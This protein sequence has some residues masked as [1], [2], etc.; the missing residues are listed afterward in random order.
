VARLAHGFAD[1][2]VGAM[3]LA[4]P[5]DKPLV[6]VPAM[7]HQMLNAPV[8]QENLS[9][10]GR[11]GFM[12]TPTQNGS[13][14]CGEEGEGRMLE[15]EQILAWIFNSREPRGRVL[16]TGG[17]TREPIDGI[18]FLS[19]VSTGQTAA[20]L[21]EEL[22][23]RGWQVTHL[24]GEGAA[25][26]ARAT[27]RIV[28]SS[29]TDLDEKLRRELGAHDYRAVIH[30]AAVSDYSVVDARPDVKLSS[31][32]NLH[33]ELKRNFKILP[34]LREY[35]RDKKLVVIGFKLTLG[36][37]PDATRAAA[38]AILDASVDAVVANDWRQVNGNRERHPGR[39]VCR[40]GETPFENLAS[41]SEHLHQMILNQGVEHDSLS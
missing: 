14:A 3:A 9:R 38:H 33:L 40:N 5:K 8:T 25:Q 19:N 17:A 41:L 23:A 21:C 16:I 31:E 12:V 28:F 13:L 34:R 26:P 4:W 20:A 32:N 35:A 22:G 6:V 7:N 11:H 37:T 30:C 36:Q 2:V 15:P 27:E 39:L 1:D 24:H 18:R 29:F 10:L